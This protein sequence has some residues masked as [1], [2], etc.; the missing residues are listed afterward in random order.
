MGGGEE[1]NYGD[2]GGGEDDGGNET[3]A[4]GDDANHTC[5]ITRNIIFY[6]SI[7]NKNTIQC[8]ILYQTAAAENMHLTT[9]DEGMLLFVQ[10]MK[11]GIRRRRWVVRWCRRR[12]WQRLNNIH[13][14]SYV[15][16]DSNMKITSIIALK[17]QNRQITT[18]KI[19]VW[20]LY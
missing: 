16:V 14:L 7:I 1:T 4:G 2:C 15:L 5:G 18:T 8:I 20:L 12:R 10:E 9:V 19:L 11:E 13:Q 17:V 3:T 6:G